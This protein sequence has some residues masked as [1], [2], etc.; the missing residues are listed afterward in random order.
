MPEAGNCSAQDSG[1]CELSTVD[2]H[3]YLS[4]DMPNETC[5][6]DVDR[7]RRGRVRFGGF[8]EQAFERCLAA[9]AAVG[10]MVVVEVLPFGEF[11]VEDLGVVDQDAFELAGRTLRRRCGGSARL[12]R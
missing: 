8:L 12:S 2:Q 7:L 6:T 9:E 10:P 4:E 5:G 11:V 1:I 3:L